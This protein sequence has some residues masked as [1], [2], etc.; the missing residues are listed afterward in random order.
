MVTIL[1][2]VYNG[3]AYL[4]EQLDSIKRQTYTKW[5]LIVRD[6]GSSDSSV[7]ILERFMAEVEN[8]VII[9][10]NNPPSGSAGKNFAMLIN[11]AEDAGYIMFSDQDD[12]WKED[13][14]ETCMAV[15]ENLEKSSRKDMP[16]LVHSDLEVVDGNMDVISSSMFQYSCLR[17]KTSL[18]KLLVQ[19][20]VTGC[21]ML[22]NRAL[23]NG[24]AGIAGSDK[25]IMHDYLAA[26]YAKLFG[27]TAFIKRPL[28]RYRQHDSNSVGAKDSRSF[29]YLFKR[30]KEGK[31]AYREEMSRSQEQAMFLSS[32]YF[33]KIIN[34]GLSSTGIL[35]REYGN[36]S[37]EGYFKRIWFYFSKRA[38]K[39]G[40]VR[41]I[42]QVFWG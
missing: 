12:I 31:E 35:L 6:D 37:E 40:A 41:K 26:I 27:R 38:W 10:I 4:K 20:N 21:T 23:C 2:A 14:I 15:M 17:Q 29:N 3:E 33:S 9:H 22:I 13:K 5:R 36:L 8:E 42:M 7:R 24:I 34:N 19:N 16:I 11:D 25:I 32:A 1:M 18:A 30:L 28:V 39:K